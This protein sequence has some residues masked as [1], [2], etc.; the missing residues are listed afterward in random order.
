MPSIPTEG[1]RWRLLIADDHAMFAETLRVYLEKVYQVVAVVSDGYSLVKETARLAP[2]AIV[3]DVGMPHL[4]GLDAARR[5]KDSAPRTKFV[6]LTMQDDPNLAAAAME[7]GPVGFVLKHSSGPELLK[8]IEHVLNGRPYLTPKLRAHDWA[9]AHARAR[10]HS[11]EMTPRQ[12]EI[13]QMFAE[14]S[15]MKQIAAALDLSEKTVEF[16]KHHIM[17]TFSIKNNA[18]LVLFALKHHLI[19]VPPE[20]ARHVRGLHHK[21]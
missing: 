1:F 12:R 21:S 19:S 8:A 14:G 13:V 7:L 4:N 20:P 15:T 2:D 11:K 16:H 5:I 17:E 9:A 6:F 10:Q 18:E 3:V